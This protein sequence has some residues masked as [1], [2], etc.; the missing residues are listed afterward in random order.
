MR[1]I[2][3]FYRLRR[4]LYPDSKGPIEPDTA[5]TTIGLQPIRLF[6]KLAD[7]TGLRFPSYELT[8][9]GVTGRLLLVGSTIATIVSLLAGH[10]VVSGAFG[11]IAI[12]GVALLRLDPGRF[13]D[14]FVTVADLVRRTVPMN[15][16]VLRD[17]GGR[18]ADRWSILRA[19]A[20]EHGVMPPQEIGPETVFHRTQL[21]SAKR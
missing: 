21:Q 17:A 9:L 8:W 11:V 18:P 5:L 10:W 12:S 4:S 20:A 16:T 15:A 13:P 19:L 1:I 14:G 6:K 7:D 3:V 2:D